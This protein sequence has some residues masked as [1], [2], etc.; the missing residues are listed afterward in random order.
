[1]TPSEFKSARQAL[2]LTQSALAPLL[3]LGAAVRVSEIERGI[4]NVSP[5]VERL[6][7][8]YLDGYRPNDWN[9]R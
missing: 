5:C 9:E 3:G 8:A 7:N 2:G 1:M 6:L 4:R